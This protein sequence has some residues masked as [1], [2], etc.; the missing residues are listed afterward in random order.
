MSNEENQSTFV[1]VYEGQD[2][3][4][5]VYHTLRD[6]QRQ[7][8]IR[9]KTAAVVTRTESG[10]LKLNHKRRVTV[11]KGIV[12]GGLLGLLILGSGGLLAGAVVG[13]MV[14]STRSGERSE[15]KDFLEDKLGQ[16]EYA[17]AILI[18]DAD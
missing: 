13:G 4:D 18:S 17:L 11:G 14:G 2:T 16:D 12:G 9:I 3:A 6:L 5:Q 7:E 15:L 8:K 10:K 1:I